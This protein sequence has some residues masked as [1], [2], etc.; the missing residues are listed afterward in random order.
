M[1]FA[2]RNVHDGGLFGDF[3]AAGDHSAEE[4]IFFGGEAH[5]DARL[6]VFRRNRKTGKVRQVFGNVEFLLVRGAFH[7][8]FGRLVS[9]ALNY[10]GVAGGAASAGT[11]GS[12]CTF[13]GPSAGPP[14]IAANHNDR[15]LAK[16]NVEP[17]VA[18]AR[19]GA[20]LVVH[21]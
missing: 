21:D 5:D 18:N 12:A 15:T 14:E 9:A 1:A 20:F 19:H 13:V 17:I 8:L 7:G 2:V 4:Q 11:P 10:V 3:A 16:K 6:L